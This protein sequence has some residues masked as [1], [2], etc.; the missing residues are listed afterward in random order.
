MLLAHPPGPFRPT[1]PQ[2]HELPGVERIRVAARSSSV[3]GNLDGG[4][5]GRLPQRPPDWVY[6][7]RRRATTRVRRGLLLVGGDI[8]RFWIRVLDP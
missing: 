7:A 4:P 5:G 2:C 1:P 8:P 3:A 6:R